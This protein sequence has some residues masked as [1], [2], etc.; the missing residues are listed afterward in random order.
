MDNP[1]GFSQRDLSAKNKKATVKLLEF[2]LKACIICNE[3]DEVKAL[4]SFG[5]KWKYSLRVDQ[6][7]IWW[8]MTQTLPGRPLES[9]YSIV[10]ELIAQ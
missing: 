7:T 4:I 6:E 9:D 5:K 8:A 3:T 10:R 2:A 1:P